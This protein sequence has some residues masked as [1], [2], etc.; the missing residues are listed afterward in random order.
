MIK[1]KIENQYL[2]RG[3]SY[4]LNQAFDFI[5]NTDLKSTEVDRSSED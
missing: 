4:H 3:K 1:D 2:Y 5:L